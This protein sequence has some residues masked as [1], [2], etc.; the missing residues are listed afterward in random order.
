MHPFNR[1]GDWSQKM[2]AKFVGTGVVTRHGA[3]GCGCVQEVGNFAFQQITITA[4]ERTGDLPSGDMIMFG[5]TGPE[6][7]MTL[8]G[9]RAERP[10]RHNGQ[11]GFDGAQGDQ[12]VGW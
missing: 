8:R 11:S 4:T 3:R 2:I 10:R 6:Q 5:E 7:A 12:I 9:G 1:R